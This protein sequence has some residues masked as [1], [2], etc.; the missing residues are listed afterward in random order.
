VPKFFR[1]QT[2]QRQKHIK[3]SGIK[4]LIKKQWLHTDQVRYKKHKKEGAETPSTACLSIAKKFSKNP[5]LSV[6]YLLNIFKSLEK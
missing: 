2:K 1:G 4:S 3:H 6:Y 5:T